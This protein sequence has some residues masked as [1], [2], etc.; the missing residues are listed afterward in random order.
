MWDIE[1]ERRTLTVRQGFGKILF[2]MQ[3]K[4]P[5]EMVIARARLL[6]NGVEMLVKKSHIL[7]ISSDQLLRRSVQ[8]APGEASK[9]N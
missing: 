4:P 9:G 7:V 5:G 1:F 8:Q 3:L 6:C 2:E